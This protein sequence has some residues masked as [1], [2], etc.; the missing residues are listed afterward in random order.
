M[1]AMDSSAGC[2][3]LAALLF[4]QG[5]VPDA[6]RLVLQADAE[7]AFAIAHRPVDDG[8]WLEVLRDGLTFDLKGLAPAA[9]EPLPDLAHLVGIR[10]DAVSSLAPLIV[11]PGPHL[12]GAE[13]LLPVV[14]VAVALLLEL[15]SLEG[16]RAI[17]WLPARCAVSTAWFAEVARAWL[18]GGPFPALALTA[19]SRK[20]NGAV[21]SEGLAFMIGQ[22]FILF[23]K[24]G[25]NGEELGRV[26]VRL[27]DWLVAHGPVAVPCEAALA[28]TGTVSLEADGNGRIVARC[29]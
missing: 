27:V 22:E 7:R 3:P 15:S 23:P 4:E 1:E 11:S 18:G 19:L 21:L 9:A 16:L 29:L 17:A 24:T 26:A 12:A 8:G 6:G 14:R 25:S 2:V 20:A 28:G 5:K 10:R 13:N